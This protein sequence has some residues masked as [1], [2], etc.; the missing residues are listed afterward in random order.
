MTTPQEPSRG[1]ICTFYSY[2]GGVGRSM[3]LANVAVLLSQWGSRV[4]VVDWDLEAPG[5]ERYFDDMFPGS[6]AEVRAKNGIIEIAIE[7]GGEDECYWKDSVIR[8]PVPEA[9]HSL[10]FLSA[11]KRDSG[12][13]ERLQHL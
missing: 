13:V 7:I 12:Y 5:I 8:I 3:A 6:S 1:R 4:L 9:S 2:K 10:D 11:G